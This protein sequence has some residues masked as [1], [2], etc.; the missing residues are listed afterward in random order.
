MVNSSLKKISAN[1]NFY[2]SGITPC[3]LVSLKELAKILGKTESS[4]RYHLAMGR[5]KPSAKF[6][7]RMSFNPEEVLK[8]LRREINS[9]R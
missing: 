3:Y 4:L 6:G 1:T 5:I 9:N 2:D 8:Q 7:K